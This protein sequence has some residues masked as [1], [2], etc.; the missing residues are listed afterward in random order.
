MCIFIR[1]WAIVYN[2]FTASVLYPVGNNKSNLST[3]II[4]QINL[5]KKQ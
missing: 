2:Y 1:A 5:T 3:K 4:K